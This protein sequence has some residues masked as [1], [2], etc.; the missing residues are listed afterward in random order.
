MILIKSLKRILNWIG[1]RQNPFTIP[2]RYFPPGWHKL[3]KVIC[4]YTGIYDSMSE[5]FNFS[6]ASD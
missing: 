3:L 6:G 4:E 2:K 1:T 5:A